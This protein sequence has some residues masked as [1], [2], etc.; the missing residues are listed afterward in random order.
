ME[1]PQWTK[2][3]GSKAIKKALEPTEFVQLQGTSELA[4]SAQVNSVLQADLGNSG[5][6]GIHVF[7]S[8]G[9]TLNDLGL[10]VDELNSM[11]EIAVNIENSG[12]DS[13]AVGES[14]ERVLWVRFNLG[15]FAYF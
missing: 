3:P 11:T 9:V 13:W 4:L 14:I 10:I 5:A 1:D 12:G 7:Q 6:G 8:C 2:P 15:M